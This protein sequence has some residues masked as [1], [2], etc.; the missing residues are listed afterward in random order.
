M[1]HLFASSVFI[2]EKKSSL[3]RESVY[4]QLIW[5][6]VWIGV[7][8]LSARHLHSPIR[9]PIYRTRAVSSCNLNELSHGILARYKITLSLLR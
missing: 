2:H 5:F 8:E 1:L 7:E 9:I 4:L 6:T 3:S